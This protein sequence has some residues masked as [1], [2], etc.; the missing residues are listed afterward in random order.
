MPS[1]DSCRSGRRVRGN[2]REASEKRGGKKTAQEE[3]E[4]EW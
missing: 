2:E 3:L 4:G 1:G